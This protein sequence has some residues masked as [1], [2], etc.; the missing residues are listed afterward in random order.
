M[1]RGGAGW[2]VTISRPSYTKPQVVIIQ[3]VQTPRPVH[4]PLL[5]NNGLFSRSLFYAV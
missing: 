3:I 2:L 5:D 4:Y 1:T